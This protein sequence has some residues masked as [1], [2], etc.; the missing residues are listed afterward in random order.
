MTTGLFLITINVKKEDGYIMATV[1]IATGRIT[2]A[3]LYAASKMEN[4]ETNLPGKLNADVDSKETFT[5]FQW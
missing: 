2:Y 1:D 3:E 4:V 5:N